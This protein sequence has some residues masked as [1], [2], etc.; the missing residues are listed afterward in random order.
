MRC[1]QPRAAVLHETF[2]EVSRSNPTG[3]PG[4]SPVQARAFACGYPKSSSNGTRYK[5]ARHDPPV[6]S[7][8]GA[9]RF[10]GGVH[11][12]NFIGGH[13]PRAAFKIPLPLLGGM[14][15]AHSYYIKHT[16]TNASREV[17]RYAAKY[18][19]TDAAPTSA[20]VSDYVKLTAPGLNYNALNLDTL[21]VNTTYAGAFP[22]KIATVTVTVVK[23]W[24]ILGTFNFYGWRGLTDP[25]TLTA[26][27]AMNL[28]H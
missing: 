24:W 9:R 19:G 17:A 14:D 22:N 13:N 12:V 8:G 28:E 4:V 26:A 1:G 23:H 10:G 25:Q 27:T 2:A 5:F 7:R 15:L 20:E 16:I 18:T 6:T 3:G 11:L 21:T